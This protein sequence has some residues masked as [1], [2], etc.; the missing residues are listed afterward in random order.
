M[1]HADGPKAGISLVEVR[2]TA[3]PTSRLLAGPQR[4]QAQLADEYPGASAVAV[5]GG[6]ETQHRSDGS[7]LPWH[8]LHLSTLGNP[9]LTHN[10][11][12]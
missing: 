3:T 10:D 9:D 5:Y 11:A 2:S 7:L 4:V 12:A 8:A 1:E 6:T